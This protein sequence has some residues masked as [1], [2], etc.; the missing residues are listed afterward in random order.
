MLNR[1]DFDD[2][3]VK[4]SDGLNNRGLPIYLTSICHPE[5]ACEVSY[6]GNGVIQIK[7][8]ECKELIDNVQV[9]EVD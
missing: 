3:A 2:M 1:K 6:V 8:N 7:C 9:S 4:K 5:A